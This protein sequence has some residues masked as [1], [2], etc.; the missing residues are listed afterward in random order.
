MTI[1]FSFSSRLPS[2]PL[3]LSFPPS[4]PSFLP[5]SI[6]LFSL[7]C[8]LP[9]LQLRNCD[10]EILQDLWKVRTGIHDIRER[11]RKQAEAEKRFLYSP[12]ST[13]GRRYSTESD[14]VPESPI[15]PLPAV[16]RLSVSAFDLKSAP[17]HLEKQ[18]D[19]AVLESFFGS[20][21]MSKLNQFKKAISVENV[22]MAA[23][24]SQSNEKLSTSAL[25]PIPEK[26]RAKSTK[27]QMISDSSKSK[28]VHSSDPDV[29]EKKI[30][31]VGDVVSEMT[32]LR[33][34]LRETANQTVAEIEKKFSPKFERLK[35]GP[36]ID[37]PSTATAAS[38]SHSHQGS[39]D[40]STTAP[41]PPHLSSSAS[42][43]HSRQHSLP[44]NAMH[45]AQPRAHSPTAIGIPSPPKSPSHAHNPENRSR[46]PSLSPTPPLQPHHVH[47][48]SQGSS[49]GS[50]TFSPPLSGLITTSYQNMAQAP[51]QGSPQVG[52][53][54]QQ[55]GSRHS[56]PGTTVSSHRPPPAPPMSRQRSPSGQGGVRLPPAQTGNGKRGSSSGSSG[57]SDR[58]RQGHT[59]HH[60]SLDR[61]YGRTYASNPNLHMRSN[62]MQ[63]DTTHY[64]TAVIKKRRSDGKLNVPPFPDNPQ[65]R[66]G[67]STS[68]TVPNSYEEPGYDHLSPT[69]T[70]KQ[71]FD[72]NQL[73]HKSVPRSSQRPYS[74]REPRS[75]RQSHNVGGNMYAYEGSVY[76]SEAP[77]SASDMNLQSPEK[78]QPYMST[79]EVRAELKAFQ[80]I[81]YAEQKKG[82]RQ[83]VGQ[84]SH[85][86]LPENT[87]C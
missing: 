66:N 60:S 28:H 26:K 78:I 32:K 81:P 11:Q 50:G 15:S 58:S 68:S 23:A 19:D 87:W 33:M 37:L 80:Y 49:S 67:Y 73:E 63:Q 35:L 38:G 17:S 29:S 34:R 25:P 16:N 59:T 71:S 53:H 12:S 14:D 65:H 21:Q 61:E 1:C 51:A 69:G 56:P 48:G 84:Y 64:S 2:I 30:E 5:P 27:A 45:A 10:K 76:H 52:Q 40:S 54:F 22:E 41:M 8:T 43:G 57:S 74:A 75:T 72:R 85:R 9:Q 13:L 46:S 18:N 3:F 6:P 36:S 82:N 62:S 20:E 39:L 44:V 42:R 83:S 7:L 70:G 77:L 86:Q 47:Q 4:L 79:G 55:T 31:P 24:R